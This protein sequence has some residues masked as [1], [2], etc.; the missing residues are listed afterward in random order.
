MLACSFKNAPLDTEFVIARNQA[1]GS[2]QILPLDAIHDFQ[3]L[4]VVQRASAQFAMKGAF[5][6]M[7]SHHV[8]GYLQNTI[9]EEAVD[10]YSNQSDKI[11][12]MLMLILSFDPEEWQFT[13]KKF[14]GKWCNSVYT[15]SNLKGEDLDE[16]VWLVSLA[17]PPLLSGKMMKDNLRRFEG[18][19]N[20]LKGANEETE[21]DIQEMKE[22]TRIAL[23]A[24]PDTFARVIQVMATCYQGNETLLP[25]QIEQEVSEDK[26]QV[27][28]S[29]QAERPLRISEDLLADIQRRLSPAGRNPSKIASHAALAPQTMQS[30]RIAAPSLKMQQVLHAPFGR[31]FR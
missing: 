17:T 31:Q 19:L 11:T 21:K 14:A 16:K 20:Q 5:F 28:A 30:L 13:E 29:G 7:M 10:A 26:T 22:A 27:K 9:V 2:T 8:R 23:E 3:G 15:T 25:T 1:T 24:I 18:T 6:N 12:L 4:E